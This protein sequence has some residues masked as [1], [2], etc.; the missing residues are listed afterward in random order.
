[1]SRIS[2]LW[3]YSLLTVGLLASTCGAYFIGRD[4]GR[5]EMK[6][7]ITSY[8]G[9]QAQAYN[10]VLILWNGDPEV[11]KDYSNLVKLMGLNADSSIRVFREKASFL[12]S[13]FRELS[14][15]PK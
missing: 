10:D 13:T 12:N 14:V 5:D 7:A 1:M 11:E 4:K 9:E 3:G 6:S 2:K 8:Y 15:F